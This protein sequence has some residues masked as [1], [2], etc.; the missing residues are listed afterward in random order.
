MSTETSGWFFF[1]LLKCHVHRWIWSVTFTLGSIH[2]ERQQVKKSVCSE[3]RL[4]ADVD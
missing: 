1:R 4:R 2:K 3:E